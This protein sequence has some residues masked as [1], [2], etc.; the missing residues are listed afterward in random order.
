M[1][2]VFLLK[3]QTVKSKRKF[4]RCLPGKS[5]LQ[6]FIRA[7]LPNKFSLNNISL[8]FKIFMQLSG[9]LC[10]QIFNVLFKLSSDCFAERT[11]E[12]TE[13]FLEEKHFL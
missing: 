11:E 12:H 2:S 6:S 8:N 10:S 4:F 1:T 7:Q 5:G 3:G 13:L 9:L